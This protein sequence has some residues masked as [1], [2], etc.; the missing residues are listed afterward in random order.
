MTEFK[1]L[2]LHL[3]PN[4]DDGPKTEE[5]S[6]ELARVIVG[7]GVTEVAVTPHFNAWNPEMLSSKSEVDQRVE[8]LRQV[9]A[10]AE[11]DLIVHPGAE[12]FL[13]PDL[14]K[15]LEAG[16]APML[17]PGPYILVELP[18]DSR[19]LYVD[20]VL[21]QL[22]MAKA[23]PV[24]AHPERYAWVQSDPGSVE[25]LIDRGI[26]MQLTAGSIAGHYGGRIKRAAEYLLS[27]GMYSVV[28][29]D[30]HRPNQPRLLPDMARS[31]MAVA[32]VDAARILF[33]E[34]AGRVLRGDP[35]LQVPA[36]GEV[37]S[38]RKRFGIF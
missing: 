8:R 17:G 22:Q 13:T 27:R 16:D 25:P 26:A 14:I 31:V 29:S 28:G 18:F 19:P 36:R 33:E 35:L 32:G 38:K 4:V 6:V 30:L 12:H 37:E 1:D 5:E 3:I 21:Y 34:N 23:D 24:L 10:E 20:D 7:S 15:L 9:L 2:H 11:V